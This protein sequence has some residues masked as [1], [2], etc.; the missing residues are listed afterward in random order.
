MAR[1]PRLLSPLSTAAESACVNTVVVLDESTA[2]VQGWTLNNGVYTYASP[3]AYIG[4]TGYP[5]LAAAVAAAGENKVTI[6]LVDHIWEDVTVPA[7]V[8]VEVADDVEIRGGTLSGAG[9]FVYTKVPSKFRFTFDNWTGTVTLDYAD[10]VSG[11]D[12]ANQI[13]AYGD[14]N[15]VVEIGPNGTVTGNSY[16]NS[17]LKTTLMVNGYVS[18]NNGSS[19]TK[20]TFPRVTG[21]GVLVF[22]NMGNMVNYDV[23]ELVDWTGIITNNASKVLVT[24]LVSGAGTAVFN[25][26]APAVTVGESFDG[27]V[28]YNAT[29][30]GAPVVDADSECEVYLNFNY[31][32]MNIAPYGNAKSTIKLGN[33]SADNAYLNDGN[34]SGTGRIPSKVIVAGNVTMNN[35]WTQYPD[36]SWTGS[37]TLQFNEFK[38]DG[39]FALLS[40]RTWNDA[41]CYYYIKSL[42]GDGAGSI[43]VGAGYSLRIDAVDFAEAPSGDDCIVPL[44]VGAGTASATAGELCGADGV[45]NGPIPVTVNG[46]ATEQSLVYDAEKG[47]LVLYVAPTP[48][49]TYDGTDY[50]TVQDALNVAYTARPASF[51]KVITVLDENWEDTGLYD[52]YFT[53]DSVTRTYTV[54]TYPARIL[55]TYYPS[56]AAAVTAANDGDT[57]VLTA[58]ANM[59]SVEFGEKYGVNC[60]QGDSEIVINK[61]ITLDGNGHTIYGLANYFTHEMADGCHDIFISGSKNVTIKNV[62]LSD[63]GGSAY[64]SK[65]TYP[66]WVGQGYTGTLV[67]DG[68]TVTDFNRTAFNFNGGTVVVTNCTVVGDA[69]TPRNTNGAYFQNGIGVLNANVTVYDSTFSGIGA[70]DPDHADSNSAECFQVVGAGSITVK[71]GS[72]AGQYVAIVGGDATGTIA[73]EGGNFV[74]DLCVEDGSSGTIS[75]TGGTFSVDPSDYVASGYEAKESAGVWTVAEKSSAPLEPGQSSSETY[76]TPEA[77]QAAA[78]SVEIAVPTA[79]ADELDSA[80]Q[81]TYKAMF[82]AKVV[83]N[84]EGGYKVEVALTSAAE[85]DLQAQANADAAEVVEDLTEAEVTLTTTP[86]LY[87]SFEYGTSLQNMTEGARTLATGEKLE[88]AR[89]TTE[90]ATSGFYRVLVNVTDK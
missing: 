7:N 56:L 64:V 57:I 88:L 39:S 48:K 26:A 9:R 63:F 65:F 83:P 74:G 62:T 10:V 6:D 66:I 70:Y 85:E 54:I 84:G 24:N 86:G 78:E 42:N 55:M 35:G 59:P 21:G 38:V 49:A 37:K 34:G 52:E 23:Q 72:Y 33:L 8:T 28:V 36:Y 41:H 14:G 51:G 87:Y 12:L 3:R 25:V 18:I 58:D 90:N 46:E 73:I 31:A 53:W 81:A 71:S 22:G 17:D 16:L 44:T 40:T 2:E 79:V 27:S 47:G 19:S 11:G 50:M 15:S 68:V 61:A 67:L 20:R 80:A 32:G 1:R 69:P 75:I 4:E 82:E 43:T 76:T 89:P 45:R 30:S 13:V 5:T 77:A 29:P 60:A